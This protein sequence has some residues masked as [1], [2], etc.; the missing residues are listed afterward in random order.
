MEEPG[1]IAL[2]VGHRPLR[3]PQ[4]QQHC[5]LLVERPSTISTIAAI[6]AT[7][8]ATATTTTSTTPASATALPFRLPPLHTAPPR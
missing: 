7:A 5:R 3:H 8:A 2:P 1:P 4:H 6:A